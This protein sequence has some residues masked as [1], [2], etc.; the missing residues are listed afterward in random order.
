MRRF[1]AVVASVFVILALTVPYAD[2][3]APAGPTPKVTING[4]VDNVTT[5]SRNIS[6]RDGDLSRVDKEWYSRLRARPDIIGEIG[7]AKFVL[8]LELDLTYG[9]TCPSGN[10]VSFRCSTEGG[11]TGTPVAVTGQHSGTFAAADMNTDVPG[12]LE[13]KW[14]YTEFD[15][16]L[17][18]VPTRLRLP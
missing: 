16:P 12:A 14:A 17:I 11:G 13:L 3:Q 4:L 6:T 1:L 7:S 18:P 5:W 15:M 9:S 2:A 10:D 8:G